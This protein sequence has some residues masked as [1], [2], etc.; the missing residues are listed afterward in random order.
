MV[1]LLSHALAA[2]DVVELERAWT[3]DADAIAA[4]GAVPTALDHGD[5]ARLAAGEVVVHRVDTPG[6][7]FATGAVWVSTPIAAAWVTVQDQHHRPL[8]RPAAE[9]RLPAD[10]SGHRRV[11]VRLS[12]PWPVADRQWVAELSDNRALFA[13]TDGRVW[14]RRWGLAD[15]DLAP[16]PS[17]GAAWVQENTGAWTLLPVGGGTLCVIAV[18]SVPGGTIPKEITQPFTTRGLGGM[19]RRLAEL[20]PTAMSHYRP[21]HEP[22]LAPDGRPVP[23]GP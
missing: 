1:L 16:N 19:L 3:T 10:E 13:A 20:A 17:D 7:A 22:I 6:G 11:Y 15:P 5:L 4:H 8:G 23:F 12:L 2:P 14:Q 21:G 18:R 9:E